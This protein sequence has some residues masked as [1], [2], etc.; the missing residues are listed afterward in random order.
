MKKII[1]GILVVLSLVF[2]TVA[3]SE[4]W[5]CI[6]C[7]NQASGNFCNNCGISAEESKA[8]ETGET[9]FL[10]GK[11]V[12]IEDICEFVIE[13]A[14]FVDRLDP[15]KPASY[16]SFY[17]AAEGKKY[18]CVKLS[19]TNLKGEAVA[20]QGF[21]PGE[22]LVEGE[23]IYSDRYKYNG[24]LCYEEDLMGMGGTMTSAIMGSIDPLCTAT[25]Y[26]LIEVPNVVYE[27]NE[28]V[29]VALSIG[30]NEYEI[31]VR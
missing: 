27:S 25:M 22:S 12:N 28:S 29:S 24:F 9:A 2:N 11:S 26:Y 1:A 18:F 5:E 3:L 16:Y 15:E 21:L 7:G 13:D 19:Y 14:S 6:R 30:G 31:L 8:S 23:L 10:T 20:M 17:E 4:G